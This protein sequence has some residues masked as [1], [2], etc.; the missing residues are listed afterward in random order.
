MFLPVAKIPPLF[1]EG[2]FGKGLLLTSLSPRLTYPATGNLH[3]EEGTIEMWF[4]PLWKSPAEREKDVKYHYHYLFDSRDKKYHNGY[5]IY[6]WDSGKK[7]AGK[8][9]HGAGPVQRFSGGVTWPEPQWHHIA[10]SWKKVGNKVTAKVFVDG[11]P[12]ASV[13]RDDKHFPAKLHDEITLGS[14]APRTS[15]SFLNGVIDSLR[16]SSTMRESFD[17]SRAPGIES[18]TL[19]LVNFEGTLVPDFAKGK[20]K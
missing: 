10:F 8:S 12:L 18:D 4:K 9:L 17:L 19:F 14:N 7:G 5:S 1:E 3:A 11:E 15:N 13:E 20:K 6:F 16:I 2:K